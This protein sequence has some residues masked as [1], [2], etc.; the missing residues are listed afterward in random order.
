MIALIATRCRLFINRT[1]AR[2]KIHYHWH[3]YLPLLCILLLPHTATALS[4]LAA[5]KHNLTASGPGPVKETANAG[6]CVFCHTPHKANPTRAL[7]NRTLPGVTYNLYRSSTLKSSPGQPSG[8]SRLCLSC[9][10]GILALGSNVRVPTKGSHFTLGPL[11]GEDDLGT[12]LSNDHPISFI[13]DN[14]LATAQGELA[15]PA[16]LT[17]NTPLDEPPAAPLAPQSVQCDTCHDPHEDTNPSFLRLSNQNGALCTRCHQL[18]QW[19]DSAHALSPAIWSGAGTNPW[20]GSPFSTV[21]EN[22]CYN[23]HRSHSAG[24]AEWLMA[25]ADQ[26][27]NCTKCHSGTVAQKDIASAFLK[28][29]HHPIETSQWIHQPQE[30]PLTMPRHVSCEDCHNPHSSATTPTNTKTTVSGSQRNVSGLTIDGI[31][32]NS[33][34]FKYEIC[35]KCHGTQEPTTLGIS[36]NDNTRNIRFRIN[37]A[38][39][40]FH[41]VAAPG[42]NPTITGLV[43]PLTTSSQIDCSDCHNNDSWIAGS[44]QPR[45]PHGSNYA[46]ILARQYQAD[47][48][49]VESSASY[50]LCYSC[51]D[52]TTLLQP[53]TGFPHNTHVVNDQTSCAVCHDA[54]GSRNNLYLIDFML[55]TQTGKT[56]VSPSANGLLQFVPDPANP[57][58]GSCSLNCHGHEHSP[59]SY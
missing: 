41:P 45:G 33:S 13:Y 38:N 24:H 57:G 25:D 50:D 5:T 29:S 37:P 16:S 58:H 53:G 15:D 55:K 51:H 35:L 12:D 36:R 30:D 52:R 43:S 46:P 27:T 1:T 26:P 4:G 2:K 18:N 49:V 31:T 6:L 32:T 14:A 54:H 8:S 23:C 47:D 7:W 56:V 34:V 48:P 10:D 59:S 19:A 11:T 40:S 22:A 20:P 42:K 39:P 17:S 3:R 9:H 28:P 21:A 44:T